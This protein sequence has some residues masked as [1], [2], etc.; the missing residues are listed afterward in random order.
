MPDNRNTD[1]DKDQ[2]NGEQGVTR[3]LGTKEDAVQ[4]RDDRKEIEKNGNKTTGTLDTKV[5]DDDNLERATPTGE[6]E[7]IDTN[8]KEDQEEGSGAGRSA[9]KG[10]EELRREDKPEEGRH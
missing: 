7:Q 1:E 10:R 2:Q 4:R 3:G 6:G 5:Q 9:S 8:T